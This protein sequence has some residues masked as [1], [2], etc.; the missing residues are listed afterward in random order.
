MLTLNPITRGILNGRHQH[1]PT[2]N[3]EPRPVDTETADETAVRMLRAYHSICYLRL[4]DESGAEVREYHRYE[5]S[6]SGS[7]L[8]DVHRRVVDADIAERL[9]ARTA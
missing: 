6:H 1:Y 4:V 5:F 7:P 2:P 8:W 9:A 3:I